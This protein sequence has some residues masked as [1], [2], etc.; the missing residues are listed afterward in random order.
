MNTIETRYAT[1]L[2]KIND[3]CLRHQRDPDDVGLLAV[4]KGH[5]YSAIKQL[6][7][8]GQ[9]QFGE[10]YINEA[11]DKQNE[12]NEL[13]IE[14]HYIGSIQSNKT[15]LIAQHF[16]WVHS[17]DRLKIAQRLSDQRDSGLPPLNIFLQV[18]LNLE[19][20]KSGVSP[21]DAHELAKKISQLPQLRL[22]GLMALPQ[23]ETDFSAQREN[24]SRLSQLQNEI[25]ASGVELDCLSM[26]MSNDFSAAIAEHS[27]HLRIGSALFG[28]R[29]S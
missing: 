12:L 5:P 28:Q 7:V 20:S 25:I 4:S 26:G 11:L 8:L 15:T 24:F 29:P 21:S 1:I 14:W 6:Y 9:R 18:N 3:A 22:R 19:Q 2:K 27:T 10:S 16:S 17:I 13:D 23:R